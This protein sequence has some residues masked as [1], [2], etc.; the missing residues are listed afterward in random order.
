MAVKTL[1]NVGLKAEWKL[2]STAWK[3]DN[4][5][6]MRGLDVLVQCVASAAPTNTPPI[7]PADGSLWMVD[8]APTGA[9]AGQ[10]GKLARYDSGNSDDGRAASWEFWTPKGG[11]E[12]AFSNASN[13]HEIYRCLAVPGVGFGWFLYATM[14]TTAFNAAAFQAYGSNANTLNNN[15]LAIWSGTTFVAGMES[16]GVA[17][18]MSYRTQSG[19]VERISNAGAA[20]FTTLTVSGLTQKKIPRVLTAGGQ[21]GDSCFGD[22]GTTATCS[23]PLVVSGGKV[24]LAPAA[25]GYACLNFPLQSGAVATPAIG[26]LWRGNGSYLLGQFGLSLRGVG[27]SDTQGGGTFIE[28]LDAYTPTNGWTMQ[29]GASNDLAFWNYSGSW[30]RKVQFSSAGGIG[31][32]GAAAPTSRITPPASATDLASAIALVNSIRVALVTCGLMQ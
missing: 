25:A 7:S 9:W 26:D 14:S 15:G 13:N 27:A 31:F 4:D 11:W 3:D 30:S 16:T 12:C 32:F 23:R 5:R 22:D 21:L 10:A 19:N 8:S 28:L 20:F 29:I 17:T 24:T 6:N 1:G 18:A 2:G